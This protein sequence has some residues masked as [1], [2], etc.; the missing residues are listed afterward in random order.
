MPTTS[1]TAAASSADPQAAVQLQTLV[2]R[3][4][5]KDQPLSP[6]EIQQI[7]AES[8]NTKVTS[9]SMHQAVKKVDNA[10]ANFKAAKAARTKLHSSWTA[11]VDESIKRWRTFAEDFTKKDAA[12]EKELLE[13]KEQLQIARTHLDEAKERH[14]QQDAADLEETE[15]IS[16]G[17][18]DED[19]M[20]VDTAETI[21]KKI[22]TVVDSLEKIQQATTEENDINNEDKGVAAKIPRLDAPSGPASRALSPFPVPGK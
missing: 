16:D 6:Q 9:K 1:A 3:L 10:R 14:L 15:V 18:N 4:Q 12:L 7:I 11:Y 2:S 13:A 22:H 20:K 8:T 19:Q 21:Q 5:T 17:E